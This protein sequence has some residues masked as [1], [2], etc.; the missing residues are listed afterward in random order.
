MRM[1][2]YSCPAMVITTVITCPVTSSLRS[3]AYPT[4]VRI[5]KEAAIRAGAIAT[6]SA[7]RS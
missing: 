2:M 7:L 6:A 3:T 4:V 5:V 1:A